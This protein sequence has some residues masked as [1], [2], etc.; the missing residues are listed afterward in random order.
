MSLTFVLSSLQVIPI[1]DIYCLENM[2]PTTLRAIPISRIY[3]C[4]LETMCSKSRY[5]K[6]SY[7]SYVKRACPVLFFMEIQ[8][9][10]LQYI[11][12]FQTEFMFIAEEIV[13]I[14]ISRKIFKNR[15]EFAC[16]LVHLDWTP[17]VVWSST[18]LIA[19]LIL[20]RARSM[21]CYTLLLDCTYHYLLTTLVLSAVLDVFTNTR[22]K[23]PPTFSSWSEGMICS[24]RFLLIFLSSWLLTICDDIGSQYFG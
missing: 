17:D 24:Q 19:P 18:Y 16:N 3:V 6:T 9:I 22:Q 13:L 14:K 5:R 23:D 20:C 4:V 21:K 1:Q 11:V 12:P 15:S 2:N 7:L 10:Q 8:C